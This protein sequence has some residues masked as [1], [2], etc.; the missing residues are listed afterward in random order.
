MTFDK[1][2]VA[3]FLVATVANFIA[4]C[5]LCCLAID[6]MH[7]ASSVH[8]HL[9]GCPQEQNKFSNIWSVCADVQQGD[10]APGTETL[11]WRLYF[12]C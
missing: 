5:A 11:F 1:L 6:L 2:E 8:V 7:L 10:S 3:P 4:S 12:C 9:K